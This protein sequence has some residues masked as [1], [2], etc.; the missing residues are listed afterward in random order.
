M[1]VIKDYKNGYKISSYGY[2]I[3]PDNKISK[4]HFI[5]IGG[6]GGE[7]EYVSRIMASVF[8]G[9]IESE[10]VIRHI[11]GNI[12]NNHIDNLQVWKDLS[13]LNSWLRTSKTVLPN[14][15]SNESKE[16]Y[17]TITKIQADEIR[18]QK[19]ELNISNRN[20]AKLVGLSE[21]TISRIVHNKIWQ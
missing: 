4:A 8:F 20:L 15:L 1:E 13:T 9:N 2:I 19:Q 16:K 17:S 21:A 14:P 11:D 12:K 10:N 7:K 18:K 6:R 5:R 3:T